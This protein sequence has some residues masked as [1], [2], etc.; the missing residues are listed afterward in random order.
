MEVVVDTNIIISA[1]LRDGLTRRILLLAPFEMH[2]VPFARQEIKKHK[3]E[4]LRKSGLD[5]DPFGYLLDLIFARINV[6]DQELIEPFRKRATEILK[7]IDPADAPFLA[8]A[9]AL[10]CP[11]WSNDGDLKRQGAV[12]VYTTQEILELLK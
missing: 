10:N 6:V 9:M 1:L 2:T 11:I 4:L 3:G 5:E 8:L 12:E 7:D